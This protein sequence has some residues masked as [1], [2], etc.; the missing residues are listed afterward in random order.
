MD[1][2]KPIIPHHTI[3]GP[4]LQPLHII[5]MITPGGMAVML[6]AW[7]PS[8][9][10]VDALVAGASVHLFVLGQSHPPVNVRVAGVEYDEAGSGDSGPPVKGRA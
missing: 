5:P 7:K 10:E 8:Q 3:G 9:A 1:H 2:I 4:G 6:S